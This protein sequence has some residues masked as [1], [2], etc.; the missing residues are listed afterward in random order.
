[1]IPASPLIRTLDGPVL[2]PRAGVPW[3]DTMLLNP[4]IIDEPGSHRLHMLFRATG[5]WAEARIAG[6]PMP[7]PIFLG[8][9]VSED[10]GATWVA[11]FSRPCLAPALAY[12]RD[13]IM[14]PNRAGSLL[15]NHANGCIEDPRLFRLDGR[16]YLTTACRMFPPGPYWEHDEPTQCA[17]DWATTAHDLGRACTENVTVS[18]L[19]EV[20]FA[21]LVARDY[22]HAFNYVTRLT[23]PEQGENRDVLLFP[24][25]LVIEGRECYLCLHRPFH[26]SRFGIEYDALKPSIFVA[27]SETLADL[28]TSLARHRLLASPELAWEKDRIGASWGPLAIDND[29]WLLPYH[30]KQNTT[31]GYTQ[32]FMILRRDTD[33]WPYITHRC[34]DRLMFAAKPWELQGRFKTPCVFTCGGLVRD[35]QLIMTYGAADTVAG[36][37]RTNWSTLL[38][39]VRRFDAHGQRTEPEWA[40][41][42]EEKPNHG[43]SCLEQ[44]GTT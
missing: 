11:D 9:A 40:N 39:H 16:L 44:S 12:R 5:P 43:S 15:V 2:E 8:Y 31:I 17:P 28:G 41:C 34:A 38:A 24:E 25:K 3:A 7:Y 33:G 14:I 1:M 32:S 30:G 36:V 21:R 18:V 37:A 26:P 19:W 27:A 10:N 35:E 23:D 22:E 29:E 42:S 13:G 6:K 4:A 20:D